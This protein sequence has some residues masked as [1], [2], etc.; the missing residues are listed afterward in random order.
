MH[1]VALIDLAQS[2][3]AGQRRDDLGVAQ[4]RLRVVDRRLVGLQLRFVL[5]HQRALG[6]RLL[7]R[8]GLG[9]GKLLIANEVEARIGEQRLILRLLGHRLIEGRLV[10]CGVDFGQHITGLD[11]LP[12]LEVDRQQ[13]A[14]DLSADRHGVH[15]LHGADA[16]EI[17]RHIRNVWCGRQHRHGEVRT[18]ACRGGPGLLIGGPCDVTETAENQQRDRNR[19]GP[20]PRARGDLAGGLPGLVWLK[21]HQPALPSSASSRLPMPDTC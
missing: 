18:G 7:R 20:A 10:E 12:F 3:P 1:D 19:N 16:V 13:L 21:E 14:V 11:V 8:T 2:G 15:C 9:G 17:D 4:C 6:V 5:R